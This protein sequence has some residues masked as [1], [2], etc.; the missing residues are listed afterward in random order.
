MKRRPLHAVPFPQRPQPTL[1][2]P[3]IEKLSRLIAEKPG[4]ARVIET[5]IDGQLTSLDTVNEPIGTRADICVMRL[6]TLY[7]RNPYAT[8]LIESL[9]DSWVHRP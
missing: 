2:H 7:V 1:A 4:A 8:D 3:C 6:R 5:L 9:I